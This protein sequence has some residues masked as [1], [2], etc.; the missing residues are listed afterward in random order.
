MEEEEDRSATVLVVKAFEGDREQPQE[1]EEHQRKKLWNE[2]DE[3]LVID[4]WGLVVI[5]CDE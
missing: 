4:L 5:V 3:V 1:G 2:E